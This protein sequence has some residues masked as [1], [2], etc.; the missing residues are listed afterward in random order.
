MLW[1]HTSARIPSPLNMAGQA[2]GA[3]TLYIQK[4][5]Q[6]ARECHLW[7]VQVL[8]CWRTESAL[9]CHSN[10]LP[11][12]CPDRNSISWQ[13]V[14]VMNQPADFLT[15]QGDAR[16][17]LKPSLTPPLC[18]LCLLSSVQK[19]WEVWVYSLWTQGPHGSLGFSQ[20][21]S[22][23]F[24]LHIWIPLHLNTNFQ[25]YASFPTWFCF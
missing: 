7:R 12:R 11:S 13:D 16:G 17:A 19:L 3:T 23:F 24:M 2:K 21:L 18:D 9:V 14:C 5:E 15:Q 10:Q 22:S 1:S 6:H 20:V 8:W 25:G 4:S